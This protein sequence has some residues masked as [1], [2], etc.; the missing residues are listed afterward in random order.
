LE[1]GFI[2][3]S[4]KSSYDKPLVVTAHGGDVYDLPFRDSWYN[5]LARYVLSESDKVITVSH[6]LAEKLSELGVSSK[7]LH[8]IPNGYDE[9]LFKPLPSKAMRKKLGL[10]LN[11]PILLSVGNLVDVKGHT[12]LIDA[13]DIVLKKQTDVMLVIIGSGP[14]KERL[15][16]KVNKL[17]LNGKIMLV[18]RKPHNEIPV[19]MNASDLFVLP[20]LG[21]GFPTVVPEAMACGKPVIGTCVGGVQ[22]AVAN[23]SVG[24]LVSPKDPEMLAQAIL[25]ALDRKWVPRTIVGHARQYSW[26]NLVEQILSVYQ[27]VLFC[28]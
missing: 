22:E 1:N 14:L 5:N 10:P 25:E 23:E 21:E 16:K 13:M 19:W 6:F 7:K 9:N 4:L 17:G 28:A 11:K 8:V 2:G 26:H 12:Y 27:E 24:V 3:A 15:Q 20:S 18:G